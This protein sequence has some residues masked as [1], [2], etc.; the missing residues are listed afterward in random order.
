MSEQQFSQNSKF[1]GTAESHSNP[2]VGYLNSLQRFGGGN[3][4]AIAESQ[5]CNSQFAKI[6]V[7]HPLAEIIFN[8]LINP[9]GQNIILT[10]HAG[11]GKST[12]ALEVY[13]RL[14]GFPIDQPLSNPME[15]RE[16]IGDISILKDLSERKIAHDRD[17]IVELLERSN[18]FLLV[19]NTGTLLDLLLNNQE[20]LDRDKVTLESDVLEAISSE[21]GEEVLKIGNL[22]FRVINLARIDNLGIARRIFEKMISDEQW[23]FCKNLPC[24]EYCPIIFNVDLIRNNAQ[25]IV[26]RIFIIYRKMYEYGARLTMRQFTEHLAYLITSGIEENDI[27]NLHQKGK[28]FEMSAFMFYNR[29][30]GDNGRTI[31]PEARK[32][33]AL[34]EIIKQGFGQQPSPYWEHKLWLRGMERNITLGIKD[35]DNGFEKLRQIGSGAKINLSIKPNNAREQVRRMLFFMY[36]FDENH[37]DFLSLFINSPT[38]LRWL[39]WQHSDIKISL[40]EKKTLES[41]IFHV[42]QEHFTGVRLPEGYS[43]LEQRLYITL[44]RRRNE[45]VQS[46]QVVLAQIDWNDATQLELKA[47]TSYSGEKR[48]DFVLMGKNQIKG[49]DLHLRVPFLDYVLLRH[50]GELG[51]ILHASYIERLDCYKAKFQRRTSN[52]KEDGMMLIRLKTDHSFKRQNFEI[53]SNNELEVTDA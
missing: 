46:A 16:D 15:P 29:F 13:K 45:F 28:E 8:E 9:A 24:K 12:I 32:M 19:S 5:A 39:E 47:F 11:D 35:L 2:F 36:D 6:Y 4:N 43:Q 10:G 50:F 37:T 40:S 3:E 22:S 14:K 23:Q 44:K 26:E 17:L 38:L 30:F 42:I 1:E 52:E 31:D 20:A 49:I 21:S 25:I 18:R 41:K 27:L 34:K 33:K 53:N 48:Q 51:E 7:N